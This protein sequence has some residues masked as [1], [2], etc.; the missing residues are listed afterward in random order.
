MWLQIQAHWNAG[1][2]ETICS[3][4]WQ[5]KQSKGYC[6][7]VGWQVAALSWTLSVIFLQPQLKHKNLIKTVMWDTVFSWIYAHIFPRN[8][9]H[10]V[11]VRDQLPVYFKSAR[12]VPFWEQSCRSFNKKS[13][14]PFFKNLNFIT[15]LKKARYWTLSCTREINFA[16]T[17]PMF[18]LRC[19]GIL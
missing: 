7:A 11:V 9:C 13:F 15:A 18:S 19:M 16:S 17:C 14:P 1:N 2:F 10:K 5:R 8:T 6:L 12:N 4:S 3:Y